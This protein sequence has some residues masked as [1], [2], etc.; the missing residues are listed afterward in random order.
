[1][2]VDRGQVHRGINLIVGEEVQI[3]RV[4]SSPRSGAKIGGFYLSIENSK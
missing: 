4:N 3:A 2:A 1:M